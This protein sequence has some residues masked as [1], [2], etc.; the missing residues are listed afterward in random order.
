MDLRS[1]NNSPVAF[2]FGTAQD[3]NFIM[4]SW[5]K[6]Y[7][8]SPA[9]NRIDSDIYFPRQSKVIKR[10]LANS[11]VVVACNCD[12]SEQIYGYLIAQPLADDVVFHWMY[13]KYP[14][15][16]LGIAR[17][18]LKLVIDQA[19]EGTKFFASHVPVKGF[20]EHISEVFSITYDPTK[21]DE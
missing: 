15:R 13:V 20:F 16:K 5:L 14:Y 17:W 9:N 10:C 21:K 1:P 6:S 12:D 8:P 7:R 11:Y 4:N 3:A 19:T 2:R 18:M